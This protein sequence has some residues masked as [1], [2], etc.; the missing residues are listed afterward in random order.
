MIIGALTCFVVLMGMGGYAVNAMTK[1][2]VS[3]Q[4]DTGTTVRNTRVISEAEARAIALD[5]VPGTVEDVE[6]NDEDGKKVLVVEIESG[7]LEHNV[8][9]DPFTKRILL[10]E[11]ERELSNKEIEDVAKISEKK[12]KELALGAYSGKVTDIEG[13]LVNSVYAWEVEVTSGAKE[14]DVL[15]DML[16][17][18]ILDIEIDLVDDE[19]NEES[20][21]EKDEYVSKEEAESISKE[22]SQSEAEDIALGRV[23]GRVTDVEIE[24][25]QGQTLYVVEIDHDGQEVD[26]LVTFEGEVLDIEW[27]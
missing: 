17:G 5:R 16:T 10:V 15:V 1:T 2:G 7:D 20:E 18:A 8:H 24:R 3:T 12:A 4:V 27:D 25:K 21:D 14:A 22:I 9:I 6:L 19:D 11:T 23:S 26:V 13:K